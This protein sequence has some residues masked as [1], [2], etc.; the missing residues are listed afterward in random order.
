MCNFISVS[1]FDDMCCKIMWY[2]MI[3]C[4]LLWLF[5]VTWRDVTW[6]E[7]LRVLR[8]LHVLSQRCGAM[9]RCQRCVML[10]IATLYV[11]RQAICTMMK[12]IQDCWW[13]DDSLLTLLFIIAHWVWF[14][15]A[16]YFGFCF[17]IASPLIA[18]ALYGSLGTWN[19][20]FRDFRNHHGCYF[21]WPFCEVTLVCWKL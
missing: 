2:D 17:G 15:F 1:S 12:M 10:S 7:S 9:F 4:D 21:L 5:D 19:D 18:L 13:N 8:C 6:R 14:D 20:I 16:R 11:T 3:R